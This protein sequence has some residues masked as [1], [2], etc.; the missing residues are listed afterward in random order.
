MQHAPAGLASYHQFICWRP[1]P[2]PGGKTDKV[3]CDVYGNTIDAHARANWLPWSAVCSSPFAPGLV[4][5]EEDDLVCID[6]DDAYS[7]ATGQWSA[8]ACELLAM[9]PHA[10]TEVS[11]S[12]TGLHIIFRGSRAIP[13]NHAIK[14]R[15]LKLEVYTR[16]RFI[17]LTG[18]MARGDASLDY[19]P[20]L[21]A[22]MHRYEMPLERK[23][24]EFDEGRDPEWEGT[25]DDD[26]LISWALAQ[27]PTDKQMFGGKAT[28]RELWEMD[29]AALARKLPRKS[30]RADGKMFDW[31]DVDAALA[32]NLSYFTGRDAPRMIRLMKRWKGYRADVLEARGERKLGMVINLGMGNPNVLKRRDQRGP[33]EVQTPL[34]ITPAP[35]GGKRIP[36]GDLLTLINGASI[37]DT[38]YPEQ[39]WLVED[40]V[41]E[42]CHLLIGK[43]KKGKSWMTLQLAVATALGLDFM[44]NPAKRGRVMYLALED[45]KRRV[46]KR[47]RQTCEALGVDYRAA[48]GQILFGTLEDNIPTADGG[49]FDMIAS[50]LDRDPG[51]VLV[52]VDTLHKARP[53]PVRGEGVYAYDR[54]SVDPFTEMLAS[55]PGR[56]MIIVHHSKKSTSEDPYDMASGS[57]GL[58]GAC[59]GGL[60][61]ANNTDGHTVLHI[62]CRDGEG[63]IE[64]AVKLSDAHWQFMGDPDTVGMSDIRAKIIHAMSKYSMPVGP[65]E[66]ADDL[67]EP[68]VNVRNRLK[69]MLAAGLVS[70]EAYGKYALTPKSANIGLVPPC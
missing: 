59:D 31:S 69:A 13:A 32:G 12:G 48:G 18:H 21:L 70:K 10:Y 49:L 33:N 15:G 68:A 37:A 47:L 3:P 7:M 67:K 35:P 23:P 66:I 26:E 14:R 64:M 45:N 41:P 25:E 9:F 62:N 22:L 55:R 43:P 53:Q 11:Y 4:L 16:W 52:I 1:V 38:D 6:V 50:A 20:Q 42:G 34:T 56:S 5:T 17:A 27:R 60:F 61:L 51:I 28:F 29:E 36:C 24:L 30:D 46:K 39:Q 19:G 8:L 65:K 63:S 57:M 58:T 40:M 54:R 44:G 2:L